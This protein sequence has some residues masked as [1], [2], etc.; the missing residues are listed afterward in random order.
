MSSSSTSRCDWDEENRSHF[1]D[2]VLDAVDNNNCFTDNGFKSQTWKTIQQN[3][4]SR[5]SLDYNVSKLQSFYSQLKKKYQLVTML[6][7]KSGFGWENETITAPEEA[8]NELIKSEPQVKEFKNKPF[9][10][11]DDLDTIYSGSV[12]TGDRAATCVERARAIRAQLAAND[13]VN[14]NSFTSEE[15]DNSSYAGSVVV[16]GGA[17]AAAA[18]AVATGAVRSGTVSG[19]SAG[20]VARE[21]AKSTHRAEFDR[22]KSKRAREDAWTPLATMLAPAFAVLNSHQASSATVDDTIPRAVSLFNEQFKQSFNP[23]QCSKVKCLL[24]ANKNN[25]QQQFVQSD[26]PERQ[27][28]INIWLEHD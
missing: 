15:D 10:R 17:S 3:F 8:W 23:H 2:S 28:L 27:A 18:S 22:T 7:N 1:I 5:S 12:A 24:Y 26:A 11:Y 25:E 6:K 19:S 16:G 4:S 14:S 20:T 21:G 13:S 9:T